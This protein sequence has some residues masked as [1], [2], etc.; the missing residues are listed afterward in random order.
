MVQIDLANGLE[1]VGD[2]EAEEHDE[3]GDVDPQKG[4]RQDGERSVDRGLLGEPR[5]SRRALGR[6]PGDRGDRGEGRGLDEDAGGRHLHVGEDEQQ[7][8]RAEPA[9][10]REGAARTS[11]ACRGDSGRSDRRASEA[12][13]RMVPRVSTANG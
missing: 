9:E 2:F 13:M 3:P 7:P 11:A 10:D 4:E 12:T 1:G 8:R 5:R 6:F